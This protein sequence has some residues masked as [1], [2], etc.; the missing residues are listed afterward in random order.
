MKRIIPLFLLSTALGLSAA[1]PLQKTVKTRVAG[2]YEKLF[3]LYK[4]LHSHPEISFQEAKTGLRMGRE[5][6]ALGFTVT[7]N[8]GGHGVVC[9][10][11][12]GRGPTVLVRT[13]TDALPV[14]E[15]TGLP[16]AS[17]QKTVD[18]RGVEVPAMHACGHDVHMTCWVGAA[19]VLASLK[20][21]WSGTLVFIAQPAEERGAG[22]RLML[23]DGLFKKFPVPDYCLAL[24]VT[25]SQP[26][27]TLGYTSGYAMAN[28]DSVDITVRGVGGHGS[29]PQSAKDPIVLAAQIILNLQTI[30]SREIHPLEPAVVT[31]GSIHGGTKHNIIPDDVHLQLTLR[32]YSGRVRL[33]LIESIKRICAGQALAAGV[34]KDLLPIVKVKDE[35]TPSTY[36]NPALVKRVNGVFTDWFGEGALIER[37]PTMGGED[38]GRYGTTKHKIPV[39]MFFLG[40]ISPA[41]VK[42]AQASG[43]PLPSLHSSIYAPDPQPTI[44]TGVTAMSAAVLDLLKK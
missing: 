21:H 39:Y 8:V 16:Y 35:F 1:T 14:L 17:K 19:S 3:K 38:F 31:V 22:A 11:K 23:G 2:D 25:H 29:Q 37:K 41:V 15:A 6:R 33:R 24:H 26:A 7:Q 28:V 42:R 5:L 43:R 44:T 30:V 40:S 13:D 12:N 4:H 20:E 34:P 10:L 9:V 18:D 27:G 36:N 32:S